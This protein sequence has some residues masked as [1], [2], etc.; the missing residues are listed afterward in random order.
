MLSLSVQPVWFCAGEWKV[1]LLPCKL[2]ERHPGSENNPYLCYHALKND[3]ISKVR[4][5][6]PCV[7]ESDRYF[8]GSLLN[9]ANE[10]S[11]KYVLQ[12]KHGRKSIW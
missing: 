2:A 3:N 4:L 12:L 5:G 7:A 9:A 6:G 10:I 8:W 11:N 1:V